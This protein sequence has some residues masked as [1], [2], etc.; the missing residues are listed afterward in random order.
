MDIHRKREKKMPEDENQKQVRTSTGGSLKNKEI[1]K[2]KRVKRVCTYDGVVYTCKL[3]KQ[4][5][6]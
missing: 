3:S 1:P 2:Y 6:K 5:D 4:I